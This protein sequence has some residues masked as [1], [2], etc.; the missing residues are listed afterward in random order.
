MFSRECALIVN[1][2]FNIRVEPIVCTP[3]DSYCCF[4][5]T[6]MQH[7]VS[8]CVRQE[9]SIAILGRNMAVRVQSIRV[10]RIVIPGRGFDF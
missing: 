9:E 2:S 1:T 6:E 10:V 3:E 4:L 7:G 5:L 8:A